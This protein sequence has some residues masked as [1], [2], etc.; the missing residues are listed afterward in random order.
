MKFSTASTLCQEVF[1]IFSNLF[2]FCHSHRFQL[3]RCLA[4][5]LVILSRAFSFVNGF[6][7]VFSAISPFWQFCPPSLF[8]T[9]RSMCF[10][11]KAPLYFVPLY[12]RLQ[13]YTYYIYSRHLFPGPHSMCSVLPFLSPS[14]PLL[15]ISPFEIISFFCLLILFIHYLPSFPALIF[16]FSYGNHEK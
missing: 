13:R 10:L 12:L 8:L 2:C 15:R 9:R 16:S 7:Q 6:F 11:L 14:R 4:D 1:S 5:S 3:C